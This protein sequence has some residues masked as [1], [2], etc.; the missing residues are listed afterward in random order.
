MTSA[1]SSGE[2]FSEATSTVDDLLG[3]ASGR[4]LTGAVHQVPERRLTG[5][6]IGAELIA[7]EVRGHVGPMRFRLVVDHDR[8]VRTRAREGVLDSSF[9]L[10]GDPET[11]YWGLGFLRSRREV[12]DVAIDPRRRSVTATVT[13]DEPPG[14]CPGGLDSAHRPRITP[15]DGLFVVAPLTK[16]LI[17]TLDGVDP[18][19]RET[20]WARR[21][22]CEVDPEARP[23]AGAEPVVLA[24]EH[25]EIVELNGGRWQSHR[26]AGSVG[27]MRGSFAFANRVPEGQPGS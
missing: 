2:A 22:T 11:R 20:M 3:P 23:A 25:T 15:L 17:C 13:V 14:S 6:P 1:D 12:R 4:Y 5:I 10:L 18:A 7:G 16:A 24:T 9:D 8:P 21:T 26:M 19:D 27:S